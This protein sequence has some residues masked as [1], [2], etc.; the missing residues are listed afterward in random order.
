LTGDS[1]SA[2]LIQRE[3][4]GEPLSTRTESA[5]IADAVARE[6][7]QAD[8]SLEEILRRATHPDALERARTGSMRAHVEQLI[9]DLAEAL[10]DYDAVSAVAAKHGKG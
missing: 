3:T 2:I 10:I 7:R 8:A 1:N 5:I 6:L 4:P 9:T